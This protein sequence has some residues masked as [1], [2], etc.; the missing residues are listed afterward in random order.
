MAGAARARRPQL[1][2]QINPFAKK[3]RFNFLSFV[4]TFHYAAALHVKRDNEFATLQIRSLAAQKNFQLLSS[5]VVMQ[6]M[7]A[8]GLTPEDVENRAQRNK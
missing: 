8:N 7:G 1:L 2:A 6:D 5:N 4:S 3:K